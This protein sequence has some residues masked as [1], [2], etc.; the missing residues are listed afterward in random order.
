MGSILNSG[1]ILIA[2][3]TV[4]L[5]VYVGLVLWGR[6][7]LI[8][9]QVSCFWRSTYLAIFLAPGL[10]L[11]GEH[12]GIPVPSFAWMSGLSNAYNCYSK[13]LFC[14]LE[15]NLYLAVLPFLATWIFAWLMCKE[16]EAKQK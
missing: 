6:K 15:L 3:L 11:Y 4:F 10:L 14:S 9:H 16:P 5:L 13:G 7:W 2:G 8:K 12:S 1:L